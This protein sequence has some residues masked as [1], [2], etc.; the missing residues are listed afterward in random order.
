[1]DFEINIIKFLQSGRN[2]FFDVS[3]QAISFLAGVLGV[4]VFTLFLLKYKK[5]LAFWY[6]FTYGFVVLVVT[7]FKGTI[8]R[9]RPFV[10]SK[11]IEL[12][13]DITSDFSFPSGHTACAVTMMIFLGFF[14]FDRYKGKAMRLWLGLCLTFF[15]ALVMIA[16]MYLGAHFLTD[17]LAGAAIAAII[18][19]AGIA[20]MKYAKKKLKGLKDE[21][22]DGN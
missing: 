9:I 8:Q 20:F 11:E 16:R 13:G 21:I 14:L 22:K 18:S 4:V 7:I 12:I 1:M 6:L 10:A 3:F 17:V 19:F 15:V 2:H 5:D